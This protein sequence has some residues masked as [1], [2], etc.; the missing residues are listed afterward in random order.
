VAT[1]AQADQDLVGGGQQPG[2]EARSVVAGRRGRQDGI[3]ATV[4]LDAPAGKFKRSTCRA[5]K[6]STAAVAMPKRMETGAVVA[7]SWGTNDAN[8]GERGA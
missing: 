4:P 7:D 1:R 3:D 5:R 2:F 6:T 8:I